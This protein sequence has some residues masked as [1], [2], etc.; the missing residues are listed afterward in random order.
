VRVALVAKG[1]EALDESRFYEPTGALVEVT[2]PEVLG[3]YACLYIYIYIYIYMSIY[4]Y[5][6]M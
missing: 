5:I 3:G 4:T 1:Y 2:D 6:Y